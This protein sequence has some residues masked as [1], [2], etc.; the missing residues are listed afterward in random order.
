MGTPPRKPHLSEIARRALELLVH[1]RRGI[2]KALLIHAQGFIRQLL[3]GL[4]R[5]GFAVETVEMMMAG[6]KAVAVIRVRI[7]AEGPRVLAAG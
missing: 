1:D 3:A 4:V 2:N 5:R 7:T 6:S